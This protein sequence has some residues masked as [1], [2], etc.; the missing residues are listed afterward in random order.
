MNAIAQSST[1]TTAAL[2][3][4]STDA[5]FLSRRSIATAVWTSLTH[6]KGRYHTLRGRQRTAWF[7]QFSR[8]LL[9][10]SA[11]QAYGSGRCCRRGWP[12]ITAGGI[13][14]GRS[15]FAKKNRPGFGRFHHKGPLLGPFLAFH[16]PIRLGI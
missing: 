12:R 11:L 15:T 10:G 6:E 14:F 8:V 5:L 13:A 3:L 9:P 7:W 16:N 1:N 2:P 4:N